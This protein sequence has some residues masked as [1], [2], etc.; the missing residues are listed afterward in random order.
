MLVMGTIIAQMV[1]GLIL[2]NVG[3]LPV[4]QVLHI[5][6]SSLMVCGMFVWLLG[7]FGRE[8]SQGGSL[9]DGGLLLRSERH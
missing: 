7:A 1:L 5:G 6:L 4:V 2:S 9:N 8:W 3:I